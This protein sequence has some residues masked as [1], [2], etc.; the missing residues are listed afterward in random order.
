MFITENI[1]NKLMCLLNEEHLQIR[2]DKQSNP[3]MSEGH[4]QAIYK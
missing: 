2:M 4:N 1:D 3:K